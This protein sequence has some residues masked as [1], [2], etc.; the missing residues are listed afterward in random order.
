MNFKKLC[1]MI[2]KTFK[3]EKLIIF[4]LGEKQTENY[5][6]DLKLEPW[7]STK[8]MWAIQP[9]LFIVIIIVVIIDSGENL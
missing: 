6:R 9:L 2:S 8:K 1:Y 4:K 5:V 3:P 7:Q